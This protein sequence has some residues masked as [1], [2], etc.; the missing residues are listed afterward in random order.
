MIFSILI[1]HRAIRVSRNGGA[2][3]LW[4]IAYVA[5][6][7]KMGKLYLRAPGTT[8]ER[9]GRGNGVSAVS[10]ARGSVIFCQLAA[11]A[12]NQASNMFVEPFYVYISK[13]P[14]TYF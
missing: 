11:L 7:R 13:S 5:I 14:G 9:E 2:L 8:Y 4:C 3:D 6:L 10:H 1:H 12:L